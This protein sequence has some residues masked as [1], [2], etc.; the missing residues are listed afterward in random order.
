VKK[1]FVL[2]DFEN[3]QPKNM[4]LLLGSDYTIK[5]FVGAHQV[6]VPLE[7]AQALQAFGPEAEYVRITGNGSNALDFH[8]AYYL[9]RLAL[10]HPGASFHIVSKDRGFDPLIAHLNARDISCTRHTS[11]EPLATP[12][13]KSHAAP[14]QD[15]LKTVVEH[16][17]KRK[18]S[19]PRTAKTLETTIKALFKGK[20]TDAEL[21]ALLEDLEKR[22]LIKIVDCK[23]TYDLPGSPEKAASGEGAQHT[24]PAASTPPAEKPR[25]AASRRRNYSARRK[26]AGESVTGSK[27]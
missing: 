2:I 9:G 17:V 27:A 4:A 3:M 16:L 26:V 23:V 13:K 12:P 22:R 21:K 7:M 24:P 19:K 20:L 25:T 5:V 6:H 15:K 10:E 8:I 18:D 11:L 1:S 14:A